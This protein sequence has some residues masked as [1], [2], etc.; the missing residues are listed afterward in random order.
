[1]APD[2]PAV[3]RR[4]PPKALKRLSNPPM[5][6][7]VRRGRAGNQVLLL[8]DVGRRTGRHFDVPAGYH[9]IDGVARCSLTVGGGAASL[10]D[11]T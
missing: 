10:M 9:L 7:L 8:H 2:K 5:Q 4:H 6:T 1:V 3:E 11:G